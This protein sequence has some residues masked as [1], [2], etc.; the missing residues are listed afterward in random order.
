[1]SRVRSGMMVLSV[2][3][4]IVIDRRLGAEDLEHS[5]LSPAAAVVNGLHRI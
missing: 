4:I 2:L 5:A 3:A 1:M